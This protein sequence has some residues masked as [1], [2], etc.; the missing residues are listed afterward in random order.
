MGIIAMSSL[1]YAEMLDQRRMREIF[2]EN[3]SDVNITFSNSNTNA[4][5]EELI[6]S[7]IELNKAKAEYYRSKIKHKNKK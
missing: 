5:N 1:A 2:S 4:V 3:K 6:R 7:Q